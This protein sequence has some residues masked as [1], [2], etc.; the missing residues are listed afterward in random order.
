METLGFRFVFEHIDIENACWID[1]GIVTFGN[2]KLIFE[3]IEN[4]EYG[5]QKM[6]DGLI[7]IYKQINL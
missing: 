5:L 3:H 2:I 7:T 6:K 4:I 1:S